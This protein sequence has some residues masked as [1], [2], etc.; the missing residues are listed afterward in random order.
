M[1]F[2]PAKDI[3][4]L[5][6]KTIVVTGGSSGLGKE[7]VL[8]LVK[9]NPDKVYLA[10]RTS[11]RGNA[12]IEEIE[13]EVPSAK[14]RIHYLELDMASFASVK[15][16]ADRIVSENNRIDILMNNAGTTG[17]PANLTS[18]GYEIQFGSNYMGP[19]L[20][21]KLLFP[22]LQ[23]TAEQPNSDVRIINLSSELFKQA[24]KEGILFPTLTT[25]AEELSSV[26]RYGQSKLANYY[27]SRLCAQK[28]PNMTST[29]L[30]PGVVNTGIWDNLKTRRPVL[31][32]LFSIVC[33]PF[34]TSVPEGAKMQLWSSTAPKSQVKNGAFYTSAG[35]GKEYTQAI[36]NNDKL[37]NELWDWTEKEFAKH[38]Y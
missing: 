27:F 36:L 11:K 10:A 14:G 5:S 26:A 23:R 13:K 31:G 17:N 16:A 2:N 12:A 19:T 6:G 30:H 33:S 15:Q 25:P 29:A 34:L 7:S 4:D 9:H 3:S 37:A 21:T 1:H 24:P 20:F 38:G 18:D 32:T 8:Q 35:N 22:L 28:Y